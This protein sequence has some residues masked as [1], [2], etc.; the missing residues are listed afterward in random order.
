MRGVGG[1]LVRRA[2]RPAARPVMRAAAALLMSG[3]VLDLGPWSPL[4]GPLLGTAE[5]QEAP[6]AAQVSDTSAPSEADRAALRYFA[7]EGNVDRLEAELRRLRAL[8]PGW[9]PPRD[10]LDPQTADRELQRVYD[11]V[12][13]QRY[14]EARQAIAER[15]Q[16]DPSYEPPARLAR[17]I[18][19]GEVRQRL[20][21]ASEAGD[22][23]E[24]LRIAEANE[25]VL[26]CEDVDSLWRV[27]E[28]FVGVGRPQRAFDAYAYVI[29][30]CDD[31]AERAATLQKAAAT[32]DPALVSDLFTLDDAD[33]SGAFADARLSIIRGAVA[34][35]GAQEG[36]EVPLAWL[37]RLAGVAR[38]GADLQDAMLVGYY[39][40]RKGQPSEAAQW[41][42]FALENG[43]GSAAAEGYIVALRATGERKD[44]ALAREV[45]YRWREQTPELMEAYLD[46]MA[47][48]LT[49]DE[50]GRTSIA[51]VE[52]AAVE[53][54]VPAVINQRDANGAQALGWYAFN[55][56]QFVIAEEWFISSANWVPSEAAIYGLALT[57][58]RI[59]DLEGFDD[60][61]AEWSPLYESVRALRRGR[62]L[63]PADPV[64]GAADD[65][66][67]EVGVESVVCDPQERERRRRS[68]AAQETDRPSGVAGDPP[69]RADA[70]SASAPLRRLAQRPEE[71]ARPAAARGRVAP[72]PRPGERDRLLIP[73]QADV[74][75]PLAQEAPPP[76]LP[77]ALASQAA[78]A[79]QG[80]RV[81]PPPARSADAGAESA[82]RRRALAEEPRFRD[83]R[84]RTAV[85]RR[86]LPLRQSA[87]G[88]VSEGS[89]E[90]RSAVRRRVRQAREGGDVE[91][92]A[93]R[94]AGHERA[95]VRRRPA[96]AQG[97]GGGTAA[98][99]ALAARQFARCIAIT[100]RAIRTG[101]L[102]AV[103][104]SAR[105]F[106]LLELKRPAEAA[107]AFQL[108]T[109]ASRRGS[110]GGEDAVYG[111]ALAALALGLT[112]EAARHA[113]GAPL[114]RA[115]R[116]ELQVEI[117]T[118]RALA[119]N[120]DGRSTEVISYLDQRSRIAPLQKDLMLL[121]G[122]AYLNLGDN[123]AAEAMFDAVDAAGG[124]A[125]TRAARHLAQ[126]RRLPPSLRSP[127]GY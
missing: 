61:V 8:Y 73:A 20:R 46:A 107:Q 58:L 9:Q 48:V 36:A 70:T 72:L 6:A 109:I 44:A 7:Q 51:D 120:R 65:P 39:L 99:R 97:G 57:R 28:A 54:F 86:R 34:R 67:D 45:A 62:N 55:T 60:L 100:N 87:N 104:A 49:A 38:T 116:T 14:A 112:D 53:R 50:F 27:A 59:G 1:G 21:A 75:V 77:G 37:Q 24:V 105:G 80:E 124:T 98:Q 74:P 88:P 91:R 126:Q 118:Q 117:L 64:T 96:Q 121:R 119:A 108:A 106:C 81:A 71:A 84:S 113:T 15:R 12:G 111:S 19:F 69:S 123:R 10:L 76:V 25:Q 18:E 127:L 30:T 82:I 85:R 94:L 115:R 90:V 103:D 102:A 33:A 68:L 101:T 17:L 11:L 63:D 5:A 114:R 32:L 95:P 92:G 4:G 29:D 52:Q 83:T 66:T 89:G 23:R 56:C 2:G 41:F 35:G 31:E 125:A 43:L 22:N 122:Y 93:H 42:R 78:R 16:R 3:L 110:A 40:Y 47:T 13:E 79:E 26:T